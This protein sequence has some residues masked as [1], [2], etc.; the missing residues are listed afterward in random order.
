MKMTKKKN[1]KDKVGEVEK[2]TTKHSLCIY[3]SAV[4]FFSSPYFFLF[5]F[6]LLI[7]FLIRGSGG[8]GWGRERGCTEAQNSVERFNTA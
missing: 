2:M 6:F 3:S 5:S 7:F 1:D 4:P 8:R